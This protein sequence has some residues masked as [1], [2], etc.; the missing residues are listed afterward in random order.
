MDIIEAYLEIGFTESEIRE[1]FEQEQLSEVS[2]MTTY[3]SV[4][5][6]TGA[7]GGALI[8]RAI[9]K[10]KQKGKLRKDKKQ[11]RNYMIGGAVAG[12]VAGAGI[13]ALLAKYLSPKELDK[14][15]IKNTVAALPAPVKQEVVA[16]TKE[17]GGTSTLQK[18]NDVQKEFNKNIS[19]LANELRK[20]VAE[21]DNS[22]IKKYVTKLLQ[23]SG[24]EHE[25]LG[26]NAN[27]YVKALKK[28]IDKTMKLL[29]KMEPAEIEA[30]LTKMLPQFIELRRKA[31]I[32][33][34]K[35]RK[36]QA[37]AKGKRR[38]REEFEEDEFEDFFTED[39]FE[40]DLSF[41]L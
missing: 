32:K 11:V 39:T 34:L 12:S 18:I 14:G 2:K 6:A 17:T 10:R 15:N 37:G 22:T 23:L 30:Y 20:P 29:V 27:E 38:L 31:N 25:L 40:D 9:A 13:G 36:R 35:Q 33:M 4:G 3:G 1:L 26:G 5:A 41:F 19:L 7:V 21:R 16:V 8:G 24:R 28:L